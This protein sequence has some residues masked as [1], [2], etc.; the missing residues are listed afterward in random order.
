[1]FFSKALAPVFLRQ[2]LDHAVGG[3]PDMAIATRAVSVPIFPL[4]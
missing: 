3:A 2:P 1:V 4:S